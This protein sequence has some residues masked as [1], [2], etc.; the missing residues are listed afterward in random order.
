VHAELSTTGSADAL[1]KVGRAIGENW[2]FMVDEA[3]QR[4]L[5]RLSAQQAILSATLFVR[6]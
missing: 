6:H 2:L 5:E 4:D 1:A 3:V